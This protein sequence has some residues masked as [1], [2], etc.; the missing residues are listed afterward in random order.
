MSGAFI[1]AADV[2]GGAFS[3]LAMRMGKS[4]ASDSFTYGM[5]R[6][7][8]IGTMVSV[9]TIWVLSA[10]LIALAVMRFFEDNKIE[11]GRMLI[12]SLFAI[13][14]EFYRIRVNRPDETETRH[15]MASEQVR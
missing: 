10:W 8:V 11:T 15:Q 13:P 9:S 2:I 3:V 5:L 12:M 4:K 1:A 7:E 14:I 6:A